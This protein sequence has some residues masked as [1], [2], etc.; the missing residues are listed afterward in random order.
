M[1]QIKTYCKVV[2]LLVFL[3]LAVCPAKATAFEQNL[4]DITT[5]PIITVNDDGVFVNGSHVLTEKPEELYINVGSILVTKGGECRIT[6]STDAK[7]QIRGL[8]N[9]SRLTSMFVNNGGKLIIESAVPGNIRINGGNTNSTNYT[10]YIGGLIDSYGETYLS[11][12]VFYGQNSV[13]ITYPGIGTAALPTAD[14]SFGAI[15]FGC[16]SNEIDTPDENASLT[17]VNCEIYNCRSL[18][19]AAINTGGG[20]EGQVP[21]GYASKNIKL[22]SCNIH[23]NKADRGGAIYQNGNFLEI[24][25]GT[26][27]ENNA[28]KYGGGGL[29]SVNG[30]IVLVG[31]SISYNSL[32]TAPNGVEYYGAGIYLEGSKL[33]MASGS[34]VNSNSGGSSVYGGGIYMKEARDAELITASELY[35]SGSEISNNSLWASNGRGGGVYLQCGKVEISDGTFSNNIS[36]AGGAFYLNSDNTTGLQSSFSIKN[37]LLE[38]NSS[39]SSGAGINLEDCVFNV[40]NTRFIENN[41]NTSQGGAI[42]LHS[43]F[44]SIL[45]SKDNT[46][47]GNQGS[48]G[49]AIYQSVGTIRFRGENRFER[50]VA[51]GGYGGAI[52][53]NITG[54]GYSNFIFEGNSCFIENEASNLGGAIC[55]INSG[56]DVSGSANLEFRNNRAGQGGAIYFESSEINLENALLEGN[57]ADRGCG[58]ALYLAESNM[59]VGEC[60]FR[61][62]QAYTDGGAIAVFGTTNTKAVLSVIQPS[63]FYS[64]IA[65]GAGGAIFIQN[66]K[67]SLQKADLYKNTAIYGGGIMMKDSEIDVEGAKIHENTG[68][69]QGGGFAVTFTSPTNAIISGADI[70]NNNSYTGGGI[71]L[72]AGKYTIKGCNI[73]GNTAQMAGGGIYVANSTLN[74]SYGLIYGNNAAGTRLTDGVGGGIYVDSGNL[75]LNAASTI[76]I[77]NNRAKYGG[78]D[79]GI[80]ENSSAYIPAL[81]NMRL[82]GYTGSTGPSEV[83]WVEDYSPSDYK[84]QGSQN[85]GRFRKLDKFTDVQLLPVNETHTGYL[86]ATIGWRSNV[87]TISKTGL[88]KGE[89]AIFDV[90][91]INDDGSSEKL[92]TVS[93]TGIDKVAESLFGDNSIVGSCVKSLVVF[94]NETYRVVENSWGWTYDS[95]NREITRRIRYDDPVENKTFKFHNVKKTD[96]P[97]HAESV[98]RNSWVP[99]LAK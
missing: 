2:F 93:L 67:I 58:G 76:G 48:W 63:E 14:P 13:E 78:D 92:Y 54:T 51:T 8:N 71:Y 37:S 74:Y 27:I 56:F 9:S 82:D 96:V 64:N 45:D 18:C 62:N 98:V 46:F 79:L 1:S 33:S 60:V 44:K 11:G 38:K 75:F 39:Q 95:E 86:M 89:S 15:M 4:K 10:P 83:F 52:A 3:C 12:V 49:G 53:S 22:I 72:N 7:I 85:N 99:Q 47:I 5:N 68:Y 31:S 16:K 23:D 57:Y 55:S 81:S 20:Y 19:G 17:M 21:T 91:R 35:V 40:E 66:G 29:Y 24:S 41:A 73:F 90:Y 97:K 59:S 94:D 50:N 61:D 28:G 25:Q 6:N 84:Y 69:G 88:E 70:Y 30:E 42:F 65:G 34:K 87:I 77:Y 32:P 80:N 43:N 26:R 36:F